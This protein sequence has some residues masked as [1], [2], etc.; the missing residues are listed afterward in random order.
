MSQPFHTEKTI[1]KVPGAQIKDFMLESISKE[2]RFIRRDYSGNDEYSSQLI[3]SPGQYLIVLHP[4]M[5]RGSAKHTWA[6]CIVG[7]VK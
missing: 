7:G 1:Y 6:R 3:L 2:E 5:N 4:E